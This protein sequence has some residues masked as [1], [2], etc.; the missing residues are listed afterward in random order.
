[1]IN[2]KTPSVADTDF[3]DPMATVNDINS[4]TSND[5]CL[6]QSPLNLTRSQGLLSSISIFIKIM[7]TMKI[8]ILLLRIIHMY[9]SFRIVRSR[10]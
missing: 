5:D 8:S 1:M 10:W 7:H 4:E 2:D 9:I 6:S 3:D